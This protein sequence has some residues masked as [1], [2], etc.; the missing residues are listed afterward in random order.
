[1]GIVVSTEDRR[2]IFDGECDRCGYCC[3]TLFFFLP[4]EGMEDKKELGKLFSHHHCDVMEYP[5]PEGKRLGIRI[6]LAC[7]YLGFDKEKGV[8]ACTIY[9]TRPVVCKDYFCKRV[10]DKVAATL[11]QEAM[12]EE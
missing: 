1:M 4:N 12:T 11:A 3:S 7:K 10:K 8:Y 2:T 5:T 9:E 6:P